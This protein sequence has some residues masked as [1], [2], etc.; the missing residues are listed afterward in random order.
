VLSDVNL[1][2]RAVN[3]NR[4][5][6]LVETEKNLSPLFNL[7]KLHTFPKAFDPIYGADVENFDS[8]CA[9]RGGMTF[10]KIK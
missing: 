1:R 8:D 6:Y 5:G 9:K 7:W 2:L 4:I 3:E 10:E